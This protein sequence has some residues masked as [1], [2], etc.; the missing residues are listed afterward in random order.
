[1]ST[2]PNRTPAPLTEAERIE[3]G[4]RAASALMAQNGGDTAKAGPATE[5]EVE[6]LE[7]ILA[8]QDH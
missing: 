3:L 7:R 8:D 6:F 5:G 1:M 4:G 2:Q